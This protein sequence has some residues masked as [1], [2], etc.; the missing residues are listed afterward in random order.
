VAHIDYAPIAPESQAA[1]LSNMPSDEE[2]GWGAEA[3]NDALRLEVET[4]C[5][6]SGLP[7][8]PVPPCPCRSL[9]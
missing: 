9:S 1:W 6:A 5:L 2:A 4:A 8:P 7:P 3:N